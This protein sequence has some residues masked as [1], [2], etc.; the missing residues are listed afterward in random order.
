MTHN[1]TP[2]T[3]KLACN[4]HDKLIT[5]LQNLKTEAANIR[6]AHS[7]ADWHQIVPITY[8]KFVDALKQVCEALGE[9]W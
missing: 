2:W 1:P 7:E 9:E 8:P 6:A 4:S 5:T 3:V